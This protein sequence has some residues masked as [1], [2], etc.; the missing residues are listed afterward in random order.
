MAAIGSYAI[1]DT[2]WNTDRTR[3]TGFNLSH[4]ADRWFLYPHQQGDVYP[5]TGALVS[6]KSLDSLYAEKNLLPVNSRRIPRFALNAYDQSYVLQDFLLPD[7]KTQ[8][9]HIHTFLQRA[10][11]LRYYSHRDYIYSFY[12]YENLKLLFGRDVDIKKL[13]QI[14]S[15]NYP[16]LSGEGLLYYA[17]NWTLRF[18]STFMERDYTDYVP[19]ENVLA[20]NFSRI[21][22]VDYGKIALMAV[23]GEAAMVKLAVLKISKNIDLSFPE[24]DAISKAIVH[25][26]FYGHS[27]L[28]LE[29]FNKAEDNYNKIV[30]Y[31][32]LS[33]DVEKLKFDENS[34]GR[35]IQFELSTHSANNDQFRKTKYLNSLKFSQ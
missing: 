34:Y 1:E 21:N 24:R 22:F 11:D 3:I 6:S 25:F 5:I 30:V 20:E 35:P 18:R 14:K 16:N 10:G 26:Y 13:F 28:E 29:K 33:I 2:L 7:F 8:E 4:A 19:L 9:Q 23:D 17:F 12:D 31:I 27:D 15:S 32:Q